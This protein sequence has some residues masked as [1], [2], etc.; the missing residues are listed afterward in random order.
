MYGNI[1]IASVLWASPFVALGVYWMHR[2]RKENDLGIARF[3]RIAL[4][5]LVLLVFVGSIGFLTIFRNQPGPDAGLA[6]SVGLAF[7]LVGAVLVWTASALVA[8]AV[9][10]T[11]MT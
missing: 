7:S 5:T 10:R 4:R 1:A 11:R 2:A 8:F 6:V 9:L 3:A